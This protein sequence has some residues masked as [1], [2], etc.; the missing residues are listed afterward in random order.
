MLLVLRPEPGLAATLASARALGLN[1]AGHALSRIVPVAWDA[2]D[3]AGIDALLIG[4]ANVFV[5]GGSGLEVFKD[6][7]VHV[8]GAATADAA[9]EAGFVVAT[10]GKGGLQKVLDTLTPP[11]RLLRIAGEEHIALDVPHGIII[12]T[13][14]AYRNQMLPLDHA[15]PLLTR[16]KAV[17][18]LHSA[19]TA[20]HFAQE[21]QRLGLDRSDL[22]IAALGPRIA[23]AAGDGWRAV[24][25][26]PQPDDAALLE[27]ACDICNDTSH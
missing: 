11:L 9:H 23:A 15:V 10:Q 14:I 18:L 4:S 5:H 12:T 27:M 6:K 25:I 8:V 16:S 17:T 19:A 2:P 26:A 21:C 7:P 3:P 13:V 20:R 1:A 24:H 22:A